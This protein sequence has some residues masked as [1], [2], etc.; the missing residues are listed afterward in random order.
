MVTLV[1]MYSLSQT[2][3]E[4]RCYQLLGSAYIGRYFLL[5]QSM[6]V[7]WICLALCL[8]WVV[9][10]PIAGRLFTRDARA[11]IHV[12]SEFHTLDPSARA[13]SRYVPV[14]VS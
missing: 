7:Y 9:D 1:I 6:F 4:E 13:A 2:M 5:S 12:M 10:Q 8:A 3:F 11:H 14:L